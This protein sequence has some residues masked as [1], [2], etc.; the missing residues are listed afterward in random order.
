MGSDRLT[1]QSEDEGMMAFENGDNEKPFEYDFQNDEAN[2]PFLPPA[3]AKIRP[4]EPLKG[5]RQHKPIG[6]EGTGGGF[7]AVGHDESGLIDSDAQEF[8]MLEQR[9]AGDYTPKVVETD[10]VSRVSSNSLRYS[11]LRASFPSQS[12]ATKVT[13]SSILKPTKT[14]QKSLLGRYNQTLAKHSAR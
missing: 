3:S 12:G 1:L 5:S 2:S 14:P 11:A 10:N 4:S 8:L 6:V 7:S 13:T 9:T